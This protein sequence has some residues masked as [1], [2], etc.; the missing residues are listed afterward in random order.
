MRIGTLASG[1]DGMT[2]RTTALTTPQEGWVFYAYCARGRHTVVAP[3]RGVRHLGD[4]LT[5]PERFECAQHPA[6]DPAKLA[7]IGMGEMTV[8]II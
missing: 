4:L 5:P 3:N 7:I 2:V 1:N 8:I 6:L